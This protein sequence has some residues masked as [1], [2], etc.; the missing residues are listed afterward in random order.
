[1]KPKLGMS[2]SLQLSFPP[3]RRWDLRILLSAQNSAATRSTAI[4]RLPWQMHELVLIVRALSQFHMLPKCRYFRGR[5]AKLGSANAPTRPHRDRRDVRE[6]TFTP[7]LLRCRTPHREGGICI[8]CV[9]PPLRPSPTPL[10][11]AST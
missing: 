5:A 2:D 10:R 8:P 7:F 1:M 11:P 6:A 3:Q 4:C 9:D